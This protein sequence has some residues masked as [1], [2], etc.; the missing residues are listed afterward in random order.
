MKKSMV[1]AD[2]REMEEEKNLAEF[3]S[4]IRKTDMQGAEAGEHPGDESLQ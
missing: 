1:E 2:I 4:N 3:V